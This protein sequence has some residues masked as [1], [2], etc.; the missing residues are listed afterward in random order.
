M[1]KIMIIVLTLLVVFAAGLSAN[2]IKESAKK[3][4]SGSGQGKGQGRGAGGEYKENF[5]EEL[6][7]VYGIEPGSGILNADE[8]EGLLLMVE[9]EKLAR[10]VYLNLYETWNVPIFKNIAE[11]EQQH[12]EAVELML[13]A[14]NVS[15]PSEIGTPG[16]YDSAIIQEHY[17][18]L[19]SAGEESVEA[20]LQVGATIE[21]LDIADLQNL[22][23]DAENDEIKIL[24]QNLMKGSRNH[25]R[26]F[27][28]QLAKYNME[29]I[30]TYVDDEYYEKILKYN[31]ESAPI[32]DPDYSI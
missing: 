29:Y 28:S 8:K 15:L 27:S 24:Y 4:G 9:E 31:R 16:A 19:T 12:M 17:D 26:S 21:D 30:P 25:M 10:D 18:N 20:A 22:I 23:S 6:S 32:T 11:S 5:I 14:Y 2:G 13:K 7:E 3:Y 1:K